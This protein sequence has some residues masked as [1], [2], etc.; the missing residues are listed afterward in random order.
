M[1]AEIVDIFSIR[2]RSGE[3][4]GSE[5]AFMEVK[6]LYRNRYVNYF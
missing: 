2:K 6:A 4:F 3:D 5:H 1:E